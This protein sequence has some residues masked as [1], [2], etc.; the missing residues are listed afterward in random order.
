[1]NKLN[2]RGITLIELLL[3]LTILSIFMVTVTAFI[4]TA[5]KSTKKTKK[6]VTV[7]QEAKEVYDTI[8]DALLQS[9]SVIFTTTSRVSGDA[10]SVS[11]DASSDAVVRK[12]DGFETAL[13]AGNEVAYVSKN[14]YD[15]IEYAL[16]KYSGSSE[17]LG[18][19]EDSLG[20]YAGGY[21]VSGG[22]VAKYKKDSLGKY[23][24]YNNSSFT[25]QLN[26]TELSYKTDTKAVLSYAQFVASCA[27][28]D[29]AIGSGEYAQFEDGVY[30]L[31]TLSTGPIA[32]SDGQMTCSTIVYEDGKI[33]LNRAYDSASGILG[34]QKDGK[35]R[36]IDT[37]TES[38]AVIAD[39]CKS[40]TV[41][42]KD[43]A[44]VL[45]ITLSNAGYSYTYGGTVKVRNAS[46]MK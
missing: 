28:L 32:Y 11:A 25:S 14:A 41:E 4:A 1:M 16:W 45:T 12:T 22:A 29:G 21:R 46:V 27:A 38:S 39:N 5:T 9:T 6:Q 13:G 2:N 34:G 31:K 36:L 42:A 23:V 7:E 18:D 37:S 3:A 15:S 35:T 20:E 40:F 26:G 17:F 43:G 24:E 33:Y 44:L 19:H 10:T 8:Y 30:E